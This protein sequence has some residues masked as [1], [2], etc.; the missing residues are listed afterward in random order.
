MFAEII[1]EVANEMSEVSYV[2]YV[3]ETHAVVYFYSNSRKSD[4]PYAF[5]LC[6]DGTVSYRPMATGPYAIANAPKFFAREVAERLG[7]L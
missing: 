7:L 2:E 4:Y 5:D 6:D 3:D 1:N